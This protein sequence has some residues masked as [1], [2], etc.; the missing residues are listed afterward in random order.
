MTKKSETISFRVTEET[1]DEIETWAENNGYSG[2]ADALRG[3]IRTVVLDDEMIQDFK[4]SEE[5]MEKLE[6]LEEEIREYNRPLWVRL[7]G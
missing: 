6:Q 5:I 4:N 7:F 1:R 3:M 2:E